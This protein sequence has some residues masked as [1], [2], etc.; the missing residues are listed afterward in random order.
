MAV[1]TPT[2]PMELL[3]MQRLEAAELKL[4]NAD[5]GLNTIGNYLLPFPRGGIDTRNLDKYRK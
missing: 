4:N 2:T 3:L 1:P 5:T